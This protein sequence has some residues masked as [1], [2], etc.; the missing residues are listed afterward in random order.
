[1][2]TIAPA[3]PK[4]SSPPPSGTPPLHRITVDEYERIIASGALEDPARIELID[5]YMVDKMA[6]SPGHSFSTI[7]AHQALSGR[8]LAGWSARMEQPVRIPAHDEPEPDISIVRGANADYRSRVPE[9]ADVALLVEVS[10]WTLGQDRGVKLAAYA[11]DGIPVYW[12]VN[13]VDR[14][15]EVYTRPVKAGRYR[16]RKDYKP[17]QQVPVVIAGQQLPPIAVDDILP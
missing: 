17:G 13:L 5:G 2:A 9:P 14:Q 10:D 3:R 15:V 4:T 7:E 1:M 16:S 8:L 12:I 6:K 11:K